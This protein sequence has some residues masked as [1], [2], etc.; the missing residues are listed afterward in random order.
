MGKLQKKKTSVRVKLAAGLIA[1]I[2]IAIAGA[3]IFIDIQLNRIGDV[4]DFAVVP[5]ENEYFEP[6]ESYTGANGV[7][8]SVESG[9]AGISG[10]EAAGSAAETGGIIWPE[11]GDIPEDRDYINI[12]L[13]GQDRRP[14][15]TGARSDTMILCTVNKKN[16]T[17]K[18]TSL[19]RDLYVQIPGYSD[20]RINAAYAF[21]GAE[22]LDRTIEKNFQV[23]I[24]GNVEV[25]FERFQQVID[26]IGGIDISINSAEEAYLKRKGFSGLSAG[27]VHMDGP[28]A[29]AYSRIRYIGNADYERTERQKRVL[30]TAYN[31]IKGLKLPQI[32]KLLNDTL[33]MVKTD[34]SNR[35]IVGYTTGVMLMGVEEIQTYRI[36][37]D[38]TFTPKS[39]R[40]MS[41][42]VPDLTANRRILQD[43]IRSAEAETFGFR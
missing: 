3:L 8:G 23:H 2:V 1:A 15:G 35:Q 30:I 21:G 17:I 36:P 27:T 28:L 37:A 19:M 10:E 11:D 22:L 7:D 39:I 26:K 24:D 20:N 12:L 5:P 40:R 16:N 42:L 43:I 4:E 38:G 29:L 41:V 31:D 6:D 25:D 13:I 18:L 33:P 14:G 32:L 9:G 34:L